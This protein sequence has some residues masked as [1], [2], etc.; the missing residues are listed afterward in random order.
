MISFTVKD[1]NA[2]F[3]CD[4]INNASNNNKGYKQQE[5]QGPCSQI[6]AQYTVYNLNTISNV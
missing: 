4:D 6:A 2:L 1:K 3:K 5:Q